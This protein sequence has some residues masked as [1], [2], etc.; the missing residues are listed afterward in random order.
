MQWHLKTNK[1]SM[2]TMN[3]KSIAQIWFVSKVESL[4]P[5]LLLKT[6]AISSHSRLEHLEVQS[7]PESATMLRIGPR[8]RRKQKLSAPSVLRLANMHGQMSCYSLNTQVSK[9]WYLMIKFNCM[10]RIQS[11]QPWGLERSRGR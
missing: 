3:L 7:M 9:D 4:Q 8:I 10:Y 1:Q 2:L 5:S 11:V 6:C